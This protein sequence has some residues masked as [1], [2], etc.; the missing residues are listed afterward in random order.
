MILGHNEIH[1]RLAKGE[2]FRRDAWDPSCTKEAS[3]A[4]RAASDGLI[5]E[6]KPFK[7]NERHVEGNIVIKPGK[8]A[9]ISTLERLNMPGDLV[10]Q[11]F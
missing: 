4:L 8:I 10:V 11:H 7:P 5:L 2:V 3:Y 1:N 9:I 6:G